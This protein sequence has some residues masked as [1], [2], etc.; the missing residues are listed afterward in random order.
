MNNGYIYLLESINFSKSYLGSTDNPSRRIA[1]HNNGKCKTT[2]KFKP[3]KCIFIINVGDLTTAKKIE[4][5]L[6]QQKEKL[7]VQNIIKSM[8]R[9]FEKNG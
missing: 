7:T 2:D 3:W 9:Y 4:Y 5:Y 6:K 1:E 8:N